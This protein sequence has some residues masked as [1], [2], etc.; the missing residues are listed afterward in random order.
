MWVVRGGGEGVVDERRLIVVHH[1]NMGNEVFVGELVE[2]VASDF[3]R[4]W[5]APFERRRHSG[6]ETQSEQDTNRSCKP[7]SKNNHNVLPANRRGAISRS[8]TFLLRI[9]KLDYLNTFQTVFSLF[10]EAF[11][12]FKAVLR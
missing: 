12:R 11:L 2:S 10:T 1:S 9:V 5:H 4:E 3:K 7:K 6:G 8:L